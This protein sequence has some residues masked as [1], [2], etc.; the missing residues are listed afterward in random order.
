MLWTLVAKLIPLFESDSYTA[1]EWIQPFL[2][3]F[4]ILHIDLGNKSI[5]FF[6]KITVQ[7]LCTP[8]LEFHSIYFVSS[9]Y[10]L[11]VHEWTIF[12]ES[13][14]LCE[15][16]LSVAYILAVGKEYQRQLNLMPTLAG[17]NLSSFPTY[18]T[19][20][21]SFPLFICILREHNYRQQQKGEFN[22]F[23]T[24]VF[25][26]PLHQQELIAPQTIFYSSIFFL[27]SHIKILLSY[28]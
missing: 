10:F 20:I 15:V 23:I 17:L 13:G 2:L 21:D 16:I 19:L 8:P 5:H 22:F 28:C 18:L 14:S 7:Q 6:I 26:I 11:P 4:C 25:H 9:I 27:G 3:L 1:Y 12:T 24:W